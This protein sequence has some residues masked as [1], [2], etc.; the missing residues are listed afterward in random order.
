MPWHH[1]APRYLQLLAGVAVGIRREVRVR[2]RTLQNYASPNA[3]GRNYYT[4]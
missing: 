1:T 3:L 4:V 2:A